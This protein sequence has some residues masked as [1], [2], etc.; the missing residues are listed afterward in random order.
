[1]GAVDQT[2][3]S[4]NDAAVML[5]AFAGTAD[6]AREM[7]VDELA[8]DLIPSRCRRYIKERVDSGWREVIDDAP[9][10]TGFWRRFND[11]ANRLEAQWVNDHFAVRY[12]E[13]NL[14]AIVEQVH[15]VQVGAEQV[16][17]MSCF[18][19]LSLAKPAMI[20]KTS[21][22]PPQAGFS[23]LR[24]HKAPLASAMQMERFCQALLA[25]AD[26][27]PTEVEAHRAARAAL[28]QNHVPRDRFLE[29]FRVIRGH[30]SRG[31]PKA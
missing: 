9:V 10:P 31:R 28:A 19:S 3:I 18:S 14:H 24:P 16:R 8:A 29:V 26:R 23:S 21:P 12:L 1:M 4:A 30:K 17:A 13:R 22:N 7:L 6:L 20:Q 15:G 2:W 5:L 25:G 27:A 11:P